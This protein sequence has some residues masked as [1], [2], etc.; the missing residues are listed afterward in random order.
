MISISDIFTV[1]SR[2]SR[3]GLALLL[4]LFGAGVMVRLASSGAEEA[5]AIPAPAADLAS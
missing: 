5:R 2:T 1:R 3:L 4:V